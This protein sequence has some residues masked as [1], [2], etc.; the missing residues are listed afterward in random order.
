M[1]SAE[2]FALAL[3]QCPQ[4]TTLGD[5]TAGSSG[6]PRCVEPGVGIVVNLPRWIDID[7]Q[8]KP[9]DA[10]GVLPRVKVE[11]KPE[12]FTGDR[13]PVLAAALE[14]LRGP[15]ETGVPRE[16]LA[17]APRLAAVCGPPE[18][19]F[20]FAGRWGSRRRSGH[21]D[22]RPLRSADGPGGRGALLD[23]ISR[24]IRKWRSGRFPFARCAAICGREPRV[25]F[26]GAPQTGHAAPPG[27][28]KGSRFA[29][30]GQR[31]F[32]A[33]VSAM[34]RMP[35]LVRSDGRQCWN[36]FRNMRVSESLV[37]SPYEAIQEKDTGFCDPICARPVRERGGTHP[38]P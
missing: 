26:P 7:P 28:S 6:N 8:G 29:F 18:G 16:G 19:H 27:D 17:G 33:D 2:S 4:V 13:D 20:R 5:R 11:A 34:M 14:N 35:Y 22:P 32:V 31:Q 37:V 10:V 25:P 3:A 23:G 1:S 9:I 21:R 30:Q 24:P 12:D 38:Q 36:L 15:C